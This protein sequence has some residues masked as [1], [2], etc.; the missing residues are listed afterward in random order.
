VLSVAE[1]FPILAVTNR[2]ERATLRAARKMGRLHPAP[3]EPG[4]ADDGLA[5]SRGDLEQLTACHR[6]PYDKIDWAPIAAGQPLAP[7]VRTHE[8]GRIARRTL[9][10]YEPRWQERIFGDDGH[11]RRLLAGKVAEADHADEIAFRQL[12]A[13]VE[14][15]N[16]EILLARGVLALDPRSIKQA[17]AAR[18]QLASLTP[19][20][21]TLSLSRPAPNRVVVTVEAIQV[22]D[23]PYERM[24]GGDGRP[25]R[26]EPIPEAE[27]RRIHLA[28]ICAASLRVGGEM[29]M[30]LPIDAVEVIVCCE[31]SGERRSQPEPVLQIRIPNLAPKDPAWRRPV[32][33][34]RW[35]TASRP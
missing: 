9:A 5:V 34:G 12:L 14:A 26:R 2:A 3:A 33:T 1:A 25:P 11:R 15:H 31:R 8:R 22:E 32:W 13:K 28:A 17:V 30:L 20:V 16:A 27:R 35:R 23:V 7:P 4:A 10:S 29:A 18:T 24:S 21:N 6:R 19:G